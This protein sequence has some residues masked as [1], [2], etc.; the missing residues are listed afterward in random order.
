MR[1]LI[2]LTPSF[3]D[4]EALSG[5]AL[6]AAAVVALVWANSPWDS[7]YD[8]LITH[9]I[10]LDFGPISLEDDVQGWINNGLMT[11]FFFV[12][13]LEIKREVLRGELAGRER[14]LLPVVAAAGGMVA[15]ALIYSAIN[16]GGPGAHGWGIPMATDIAIALGVL[17][18]VGPR[19]PPQLRVFLL[20]MA[21]ADDMGSIVVVV[22]FYAGEV[23]LGWLA[24]AVA[25]V[26]L[27]YA[28]RLAGIRQ[29][30]AYVPAAVL[31]WVAV[32][33]SGVSTALAGIALALLTPLH[34]NYGPGAWREDLRTLAKL[35]HSAERRDAELSARLGDDGGSPLERLEGLVHPYASFVIAPLFAFANAGLPFGAGTLEDSATSAI[36]IGIVLG[37][38]LGKPLGILLSSVVAVRF[39]L[40]SLPPSVRWVHVLGV[41]LMGGIGFTVALYVNALAFESGSQ[42][43]AGKVGILSAGLLSGSLAYLT[44]RMVGSERR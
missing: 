29:I 24:G 22:V 23:D 1:K 10:P 7:A 33:E 39:G 44:L 8:D 32:F 27:V 17:A 28:M 34:E 38:V 36:A 42:I 12:I 43:D 21:I 15:P 16:A 19:V 9:V 13:G 6:L 40:A 30:A 5:V 25:I 18:L 20:A 2:K 31:L 26:S 37:R 3:P 35:L 4:T 14:A 11:V 41:G